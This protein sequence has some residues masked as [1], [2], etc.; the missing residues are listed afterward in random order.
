MKSIQYQFYLAGLFAVFAVISIGSSAWA[1]L[2]VSDP[3]A[4]HTINF[5][6]TVA[7]VNNGAYLGGGFAPTPGSGQLDSTAWA[8]TGMS[9][10]ATAFGGTHTSGD[11][12]RGA[13]A[14]G[15]TTGGFYG[16]D[17]GNGGPVNRALG[18]QPGGDDWTPG[19]VT[20]RLQNTTGQEI[21][22]LDL[23][24]VV[25][26]RNN[27][28]RAN[29]FNFEHSADNTTYT[30]IAALNFTSP[31][32][33]GGPS[34][35]VATPRAA[36]LTGLSIPSNAFYYLRWNGNDV[37]GTGSRDE[38]ALDDI[39]I[40]NITAIPEPGTMTMI[41]LALTSLAGLSRRWGR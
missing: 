12:A 41:G 13:S 39:T 37:S 3:N 10:G 35:F 34:G 24:Y 28:T 18:V 29:S 4:T 30:P 33:V 6:T 21:T 20:L 5:D 17:V 40:S 1:T 7:G 27:E 14:V 38:F 15:V 19:T 9:D 2:I 8:T 26:S 11:H 36:T 31:G 16:F 23:S 22:E 25:Y 32:A